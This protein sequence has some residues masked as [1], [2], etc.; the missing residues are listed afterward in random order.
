MILTHALSIICLHKR[1]LALLPPKF[2]S[3]YSLQK[4]SQFS[5]LWWIMWSIIIFRSC[6]RCLEPHSHRDPRSGTNAI[7][8]L[9]VFTKIVEVC[10]EGNQWPPHLE[11]VILLGYFQR[12]NSSR[13]RTLEGLIE[14][15]QGSLRPLNLCLFVAFGTSE[16]QVHH[17][18][19]PVVLSKTLIVCLK[20]HTFLQARLCQVLLCLHLHCQGWHLQLL[21]SLTTFWT[22]FW[23]FLPLSAGKSS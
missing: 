18:V 10:L 17:Q 19:C 2:L 11:D 1:I 14:L 4:A 7:F 22:H 23:I 15:I 6:H 21:T 12:S 9:F 13:P 16:I 20:Q 3:T 8:F 5:N